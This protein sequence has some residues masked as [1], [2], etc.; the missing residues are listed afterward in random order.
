M[1]GSSALVTGASSGIG[2]AFARQLA[3]GGAR[4]LVLT[5]RRRDRLEQLAAELEAAHSVSCEVVVLDL[6]QPGAAESLHEAAGEIDVLINNA[7]FGDYARFLDTE[8]GRAVSVIQVN[9]VS[10]AELTHLFATDMVAR[11]RGWILNVSSMAAFQPVPHFA[12]YGATKSFVRDFSE[13]LAFELSGQGVRVC[14]LCPGGVSTEFEQVSKMTLSLQARLTSISAERCARVGLGALFR[15][16]RVV[17]T[18]WVAALSCWLMRVV[19]R[20]LM[21]WFAHI[22]LGPPNS[23]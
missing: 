4:R 20:R 6:S 3:A 1:R 17:V 18:G 11:R 12:V 13:A 14:A 2:E 9:L 19:P 22:A 10:V 5:A 7:G 8:R 21:P 23:S 15:G 16:R